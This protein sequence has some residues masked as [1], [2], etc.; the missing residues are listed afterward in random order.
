MLIYSK[1]ALLF[2]VFRFVRF[3]MAV[4]KQGLAKAVAFVAWADGKLEDSELAFAD[5]IFKKYGISDAESSTLVK[6]YID[7]FLDVD[8]NPDSPETDEEIDLG[9]IDFGEVD[10]Y[11]VLKDLAVLASADGVISSSEVDVLHLIAKANNRS[12]EEA[13]LAL[14]HAVKTNASLKIEVE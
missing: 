6:E 5:A 10:S 7:V 9:V 11:E 4:N 2:L 12:P 8:D 14:L 13:T 1:D 3:I